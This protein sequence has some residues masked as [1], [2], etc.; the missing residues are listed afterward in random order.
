MLTY[1]KEEMMLTTWRV[2]LVMTPYTD[3]V[4]MT[5]CAVVMALIP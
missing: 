5:N 2:E 4:G 1:L 3:N